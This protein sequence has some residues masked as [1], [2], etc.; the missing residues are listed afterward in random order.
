MEAFHFCVMAARELGVHLDQ[1]FAAIITTNLAARMR[2]RRAY[3]DTWLETVVG[4]VH[5]LCVALRKAA[6]SASR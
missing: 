5:N 6:M 2:A 1:A 3:A 4:L